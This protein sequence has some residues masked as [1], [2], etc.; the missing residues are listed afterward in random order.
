MK[1]LTLI[2]IVIFNINSSIASEKKIVATVIFENFANE[3]F[4]SGEF[5]IFET[6]ETFQINSME[7]FTVELPKKG[8]YRFSFYSNDYISYVY[9]PSKI[10]EK[11]N[12][13]T[14]R[15][16]ELKSS[17]FKNENLSFSDYA[18]LKMTD[19]VILEKINTKKLNFIIHGIINNTPENYSEFIEKFG[20]GFKTKNCVVDPISFKKATE[21]NKRIIEYLNKTYGNDWIKELPTKPFGFK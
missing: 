20:I 18:D 19:Q 2:L 16:T 13:I 14:I 9:Y 8:K 7:N 17:N 4:S 12:I 21:N 11:K 3:K 5:K 10:S 15:L 1:K 6:G